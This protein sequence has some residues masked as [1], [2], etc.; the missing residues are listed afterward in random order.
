MRCR[1]VTVLVRASGRLALAQ[2][3]DRGSMAASPVDPDSHSP[4]SRLLGWGT[5]WGGT[6]RRC[7]GASIT[8]HTAGTSLTGTAV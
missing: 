6:T 1:G 2:M 8:T 5:A 4:D 3:P 7:W